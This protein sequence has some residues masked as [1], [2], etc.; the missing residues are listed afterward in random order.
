MAEIE[1]SLLV[2]AL[3]RKNLFEDGLQSVI[4]PL[5]KRHILLEK[6]DIRIELDLD[7]VRRLYTF[8]DGSEVDA[9]RISF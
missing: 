8:F 4:P 2:V 1:D 3:D 6:I 7:Q 5:G 9:F